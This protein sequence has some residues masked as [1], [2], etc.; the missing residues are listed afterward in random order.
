MLSTLQMPAGHFVGLILSATIAGLLLKTQSYLLQFT[1]LN[2]HPAFLSESGLP[3]F[4]AKGPP[5][6]SSVEAL[7]ES[8]YT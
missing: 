1:T 4:S 7:H 6:F 2:A 3:R 5:K 8:S